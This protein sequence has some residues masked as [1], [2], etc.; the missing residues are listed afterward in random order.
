MT[1]FI[2]REIKARQKAFSS[3]NVVRYKE[4]CEKI[5][6]LIKKAK[7]VYYN[8]KVGGQRKDNPAT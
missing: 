6:R 5:A 2:K 4:L 7:E 8:S 3:G 1:A